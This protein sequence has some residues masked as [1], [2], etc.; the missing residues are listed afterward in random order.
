MEGEI[1]VIQENQN[2]IFDIESTPVLKL[3]L[4]TGNSQAIEVKF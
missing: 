2:V 3:V 1:V 4:I